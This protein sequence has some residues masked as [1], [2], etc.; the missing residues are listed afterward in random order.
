MTAPAHS[1]LVERVARAISASLKATNFDAWDHLRILDVERAAEAAIE[2]VQLGEI[3]ETLNSIAAWDQG[4]V[5]SGKFD[6]PG[7]ARTARFLLAKLGGKP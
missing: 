6:E 2:S 3:L 4:V 5:V 7:S 1:T